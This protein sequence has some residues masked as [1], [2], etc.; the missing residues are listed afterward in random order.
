MVAKGNTELA[1]LL[2]TMISEEINSG[3]IDRLLAKY[4]VG[5]GTFYPVALPYRQPVRPRAQ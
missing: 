2:N 1:G 5:S 4:D 3:N